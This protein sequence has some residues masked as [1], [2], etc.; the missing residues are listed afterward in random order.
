MGSAESMDVVVR[1]VAELVG[2]RDPAAVERF[3]APGYV[4]HSV[5]ADG[6]RDVVAALPYNGVMA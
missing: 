6:R 5:S 1:A 4:Q 3:V 2:R